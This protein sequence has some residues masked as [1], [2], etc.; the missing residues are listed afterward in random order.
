MDSITSLFNSIN[1]YKFNYND[2]MIML[3]YSKI[4]KYENVIPPGGNPTQISYIFKYIFDKYLNYNDYNNFNFIYEIFNA[5]FKKMN[6]IRLKKEELKTEYERY[7]KSIQNQI[8]SNK[9]NVILNCAHMH[10]Y[11]LLIHKRKEDYY[12]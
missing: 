4:L 10:A 12:D 2:L 1:E 8:I 7:L 9:Y 6:T 11:A 3:F 5:N